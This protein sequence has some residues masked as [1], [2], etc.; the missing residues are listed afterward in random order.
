MWPS[1][2]VLQRIPSAKYLASCSFGWSVL[3]LLIPACRNFAHLM[4]LRFLMGITHVFSFVPCRI[5][6][7]ALI[8]LFS[9]LS[10]RHHSS[11][12][13]SSY[14][15]FLQK[16]R[17]TTSQCRR[18]CCDQFCYQWFSVLG[19]RANPSIGTSGEMA[20]SVSYYWFVL[21]AKSKF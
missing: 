21:V 19:C 4:I 12:H 17:A 16:S 1:S 20:V 15:R 7:Y 14:R 9:R 3:S 10:G 6:D 2:Y 8:S 18:I 13:L 11:I 5:W